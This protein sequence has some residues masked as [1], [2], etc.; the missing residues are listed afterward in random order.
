MDKNPICM[1]CGYRFEDGDEVIRITSYN[2]AKYVHDFCFE[3][4]NG[5]EAFELFGINFEEIEI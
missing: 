2:E 3:E 4:M 1:W 5:R